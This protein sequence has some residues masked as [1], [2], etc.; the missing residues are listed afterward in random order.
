MTSFLKLPN[1]FDVELK[2]FRTAINASVIFSPKWMRK[3]YAFLNWTK[4]LRPPKKSWQA[5]F[6]SVWSAPKSIH[7]HQ[8]SIGI[9]TYPG[10]GAESWRVE[11]SRFTVPQKQVG[12]VKAYEQFLSTVELQTE[13]VWSLATRWGDP[14]TPLGT[15]FFRLSQYSG[16]TLPWI[17][18]LNPPAVHPGIPYNDVPDETG[19]WFPLGSSTSNNIHLIVPGGYILRLFWECDAT[20]LTPSVGARMRGYLQSSMSVESRYSIRAHW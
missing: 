4:S 14:R 19:I 12:I 17:N 10:T 3:N 8:Q 6:D 5:D 15:W 20:N 2:G 7:N 16:I 1:P 11:L 9:L 13:T 18:Q